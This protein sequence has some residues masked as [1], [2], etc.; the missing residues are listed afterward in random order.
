[1]LLDKLDRLESSGLLSVAD[2]YLTN[3]PQELCN[4]GVDAIFNYLREL[5]ISEARHRRKMILIGLLIFNV[6]STYYA[7]F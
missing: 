5:R 1:M 3:P 7:W 4:Q 2:N 6:L